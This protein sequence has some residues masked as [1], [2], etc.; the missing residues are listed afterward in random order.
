MDSQP[1]SI[2][3]DFYSFETGQPFESCLVCKA[4]LLAGD[5]DYFV[6]KAI[7]NYHEHDIKDVVYEYAIC[8]HCA[9]DMNGQM[10]KES[11]ENIQQ[12]FS[13]Q[14]LFMKKIQEYNTKEFPESQSLIPDRC[15]ITGEEVGKLDEYMIYGHFRGD[16]MVTS[17]MPYLLSGNVMDDVSDLLSNETIDQLDDFMGEYFGGPPEL[18]EL[19]KP[20]RPVFF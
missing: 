5:V 15:V 3:E 14:D 11:M 6:E 9:H 10:S 13:H 8:W 17:T 7:R 19:W 20:R 16:K 18:E 12:Y 2:P 1:M 4:D